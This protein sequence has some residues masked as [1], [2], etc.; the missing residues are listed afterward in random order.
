METNFLHKLQCASIVFNLSVLSPVIYGPPISLSHLFLPLYF[1]LLSFVNFSL[2]LL[3]PSFTLQTL[4]QD[5]LSSPPPTLSSYSPSCVPPPP[6]PRATPSPLFSSHQLTVS[7]LYLLS[8]SYSLPPSSLTHLY[9]LLSFSLSL[10]RLSHS[11]SLCLFLHLSRFL[12][13]QPSSTM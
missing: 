7:H 12:I 8:M 3:L 10:P 6:P 9:T 13:G 2:H 5:A 4:F 11:L 1:C